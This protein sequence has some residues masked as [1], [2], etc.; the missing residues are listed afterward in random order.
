MARA[1]QRS[2]RSER[3]ERIQ[4]KSTKSR[5]EEDEDVLDED[6]NEAGDEVD[7]MNRLN[8]RGIHVRMERADDG[9]ED[10][11]PRSKKAAKG[12]STSATTKSGGGRKAAS[13]DDDD[14]NDT[15]NWADVEEQEGGDLEVIPRGKYACTV[16]ES[17]FALSKESQNPMITLRL[18][19][20]D[21]DYANRKL[22]YRI[23]LT[24]KTLGMVKHS[25]R[26]LGVKFPTKEMSWSGAKK[27]FE[28]LAD[29]GDLIGQECAAQVK[30][31]TYEGEKRN[32][33]RMISAVG[34]AAA[35]GDD[36]FME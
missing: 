36:D 34:E 6:E 1:P 24:K 28:K 9:D 23:V 11:A 31:R 25:L 18:E 14:D 2:E 30:I 10:E 33:V 19:V 32:E 29:S 13:R 8:E 35:E 4:S 26:V 21:G 27:W 7:R 3:S 22:W 17:E 15:I 16:D 20:N 5:V 12:G